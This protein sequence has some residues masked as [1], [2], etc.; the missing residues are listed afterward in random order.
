MTVNNIVGDKFSYKL[1]ENTIKMYMLIAFLAIVV[2][3]VIVI[4]PRKGEKQDDVLYVN[5]FDGLV[6]A[7]Y[8]P[9]TGEYYVVQGGIRMNLP[10]GTH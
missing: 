9:V 8:D 6:P 4:Y 3:I 7:A 1:Y 10:K 2:I 5:G